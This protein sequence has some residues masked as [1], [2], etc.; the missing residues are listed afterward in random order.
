M[1][2]PHLRRVEFAHCSHLSPSQD[3]NLQKAN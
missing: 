3:M 2:H 1:D